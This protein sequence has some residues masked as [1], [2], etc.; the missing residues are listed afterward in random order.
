LAGGFCVCAGGHDLLIM[1]HGHVVQC[2]PRRMI[3]CRREEVDLIECLAFRLASG[4]GIG[5]HRPRMEFKALAMA[6]CE[7]I[8]ENMI[9]DVM[10]MI[11]DWDMDISGHNFHISH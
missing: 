1:D 10:Y 9:S 6:P 3:G 8:N 2:L 4:M 7:W 11:W 5:I